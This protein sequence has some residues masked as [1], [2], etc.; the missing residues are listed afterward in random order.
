MAIEEDRKKQCEQT[1]LYIKR[2]GSTNGGRTEF[3]DQRHQ[4]KTVQLDWTSAERRLT[5]ENRNGWKHTT[6]KGKERL[7]RMLLDWILK[8]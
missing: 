2:R 8:S 3:A 7:R 6:K 5:V 1:I 4:K